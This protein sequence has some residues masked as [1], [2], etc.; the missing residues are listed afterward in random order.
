MRVQRVTEASSSCPSGPL[1]KR[2]DTCSRRKFFIEKLKRTRT[3]SLYLA[4][5]V[6]LDNF[7]P[8]LQDLYSTRHEIK[9]IFTCIFSLFSFFL[10]FLPEFSFLLS[11]FFF[12]NF[13]YLFIYLCP[14]LSNP[15]PLFHTCSSPIFPLPSPLRRGRPLWVSLHGGSS[16]HGKTRCILSE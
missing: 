9:L 1:I 15:Q 4:N 13:I 16:N 7:S 5:F 2:L 3:L 14:D 12:H 8:L 10:S 6:E 11:L